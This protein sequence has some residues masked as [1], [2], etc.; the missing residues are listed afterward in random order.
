LSTL[1]EEDTFKIARG[2]AIRMLDLELDPELPV[3]P[4]TKG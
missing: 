3:G 1:S 4:A 2:N